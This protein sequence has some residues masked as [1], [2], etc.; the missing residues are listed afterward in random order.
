M[1]SE[2]NLSFSERSEFQLGLDANTTFGNVR[3]GVHLHLPLGD[4]GLF[5]TG[6]A[7][8]FVFGLNVTLLIPSA[9]GI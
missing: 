6:Q 5:S 1:L 2:D 7:V 3:P 8:S 9:G 4:D